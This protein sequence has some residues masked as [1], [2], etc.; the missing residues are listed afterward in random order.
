[1]AEAAPRGRYIELP[2]TAHW[3]NVDSAQAFNEAVLAFQ[4][5]KG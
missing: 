4:S 2:H 3:S 5:D 1:M